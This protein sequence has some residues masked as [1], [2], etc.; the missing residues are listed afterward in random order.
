MTRYGRELHGTRD[1]PKSGTKVRCRDCG[2]SFD[3]ADGYQA[4]S[5]AYHGRDCEGGK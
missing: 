1:L 5:W 3:T 2:R 4:A